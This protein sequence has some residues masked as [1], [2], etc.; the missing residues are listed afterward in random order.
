MSGGRG[1]YLADA[2]DYVDP[3]ATAVSLDV[4]AVLV[5]ALFPCANDPPKNNRIG[6]GSN[7]R[8]S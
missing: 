6:R 1:A 8:I 2:A 7:I 3:A 5:L 4:A